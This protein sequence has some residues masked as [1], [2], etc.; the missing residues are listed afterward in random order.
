[1]T[2]QPNKCPLDCGVSFEH[3]HPTGERKYPVGVESTQTASKSTQPPSKPMQ[4]EPKKNERH[5]CSDDCECQKAKDQSPQDRVMNQ[6]I[7]QQKLTSMPLYK[8]QEPKTEEW[9]KDY[10]E[11]LH[12]R[13]LEILLKAM[14]S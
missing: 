10:D 11:D 7:D 13:I 6:I 9:E 14:L 4:I 5:W 2:T 8:P 3:T 12:T 1:M